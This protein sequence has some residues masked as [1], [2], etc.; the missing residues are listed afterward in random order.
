MLQTFF[1]VLCVLCV[2]RL[3]HAELS[4][5]AEEIFRKFHH[6]NPGNPQ[7]AKKMCSTVCAS[8]FSV[9]LLLIGLSI[10]ARNMN[11]WNNMVPVPCVVTHHFTDRVPACRLKDERCMVPTNHLHSCESMMAKFH[12]ENPDFLAEIETKSQRCRYNYWCCAQ[13]SSSTYTDSSGHTR[14]SRE[15]AQSGV[16]TGYIKCIN[17]YAATATVEYDHGGSGARWANVS[18]SRAT[19]Q[20]DACRSLPTRQCSEKFFSQH[21]IGHQ[22]TCYVDVRKPTRVL[23]TR[24]WRHTRLFIGVACWALAFA[25]LVAPWVPSLWRR[26][27]RV[28]RS[29][30]ELGTQPV[31][32]ATFTLEPQR[33]PLTQGS[34]GVGTSY[35]SIPP[36]GSPPQG[37]GSPL[38]AQP[39]TPR[40]AGRSGAVFAIARLP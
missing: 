40:T 30:I 39:V 23:F 33:R 32:I 12:D 31:I 20:G 7:N 9:V 25:L 1:C 29:R 19:G 13:Y 5:H 27:R 34:K 21:P 6:G 2:F 8:I 4:E 38:R 28:D 37:R 35:G 10:N 3:L 16:E 15:C 18:Y 11:I 36:Q 17:G 22:S 26:H 24:R 14:T